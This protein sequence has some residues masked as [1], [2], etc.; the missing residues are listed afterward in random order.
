MNK[1][2]AEIFYSWFKKSHSVNRR[3]LLLYIDLTK[4]NLDLDTYFNKQKKLDLEQSRGAKE[5]TFKKLEKKQGCET[6]RHEK[7]HKKIYD[8]YGIDSRLMIKGHEPF[9]MDTNFHEVAKEKNYDRKK[10]IKIL[11]EMLYEPFRTR[12]AKN[13]LSNY[14]FDLSCYETLKGNITKIERDVFITVFGNYNSSISQ[15]FK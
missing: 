1:S 12:Q 6:V 2:Y 9:V 15:T 5:L 7:A 10:V 3:Q 14:A 11:S 13:K 4:G 8:C